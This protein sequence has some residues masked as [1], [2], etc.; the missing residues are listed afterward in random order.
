M[1]TG[2]EIDQIAGLLHL[3]ERQPFSIVAT[4]DVLKGLGANPIFGVL[5]SD[6]VQRMSAGIGDSFF[7]A[8]GLIAEFFAV[9]GKLPLYLEGENPATADQ[10]P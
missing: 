2:A 4:A 8:P 7:P 9:P 3:R 6:V 5:A 1:L 10:D